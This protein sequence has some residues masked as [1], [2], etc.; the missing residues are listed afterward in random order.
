MEK[1]GYIDSFRDVKPDPLK[2]PGYSYWPFSYE[3]TGK[4][5]VKDRIDY[6]FS[7]GEKLHTISSEVIDYHPV[8]FPSD[9]AFVLST[10]RLDY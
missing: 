5:F 3:Q 8:M 10:F 6:I 4:R 2:Y 9:H 7:K 1:A